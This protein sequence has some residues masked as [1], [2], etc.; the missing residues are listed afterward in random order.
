MTSNTVGQQDRRT[1]SGWRN[2]ARRAVARVSD[3]GGQVVDRVARAG[4]DVATFSQEALEFKQRQERNFAMG[5]YEWGKGTVDTVVGI[6]K[7]PVGTARGL[8]DLATNPLISPV[9]GFAR[10]GLEG[11]SPNEAL[12]QGYRDL[13]DIGGGLV[14]GYK[15]VYRE[16]GAAGLAGNLAPDVVTALVSGGT[17]TAARTGGRAVVREVAEES[18]EQVVQETAS[19][20]TRGALRQAGRDVAEEFVPGK[21]DVAAEAQEESGLGW[22][23]LRN[24]RENY[25]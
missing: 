21:E 2:V 19:R 7:D 3:A 11:R 24:F 20:S 8:G 10:A 9:A 15:D 22:S 12:A 13:R 18:A 25:S 1:N 4:R 23:F 6:A 5:V 16:H 14:G 17:G